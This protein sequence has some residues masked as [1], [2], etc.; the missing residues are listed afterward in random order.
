MLR[1]NHHPVNKAGLVGWWDYANTGSVSALGTWKDYSGNGND[2]TLYS[3]ANVN[4]TGI[5]LVPNSYGS[6]DATDFKISG[7]FSVSF[8]L[9]HN[10]SGSSW[11]RIIDFSNYSSTQSG[12]MFNYRSYSGDVEFR[13]TNVITWESLKISSADMTSGNWYHI[14]GTFNNTTKTGKI[15]L[16]GVLKDT[17]TGSGVVSYTDINYLGFGARLN[18]AP[19]EYA[20][21]TIDDIQ[22]YE[23]ELLVGE[24]M[25]NYL[26]SM[27][28]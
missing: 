23:R 15:Y 14:T 1:P 19:M 3:T 24:I 28:A 25:Q 27:R 20:N 13:I 2:A 8:W 10:T 4:N 26:K 11:S 18:T 21:V 6:I 5:V 12:W 17:E 16:D 9:K 22:I 7:D